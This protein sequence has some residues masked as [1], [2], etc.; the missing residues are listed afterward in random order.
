[1]VVDWNE[2][3]AQMEF[4]LREE[5]CKR[6]DVE[7]RYAMLEQELIQQ[8]LEYEEKMAEIERMYMYRLL[9]QVPFIPLVHSDCRTNGQMIIQMRS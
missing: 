4:L 9:E 7:E 5:E 6:I 3:F 8:S 1:M 2:K